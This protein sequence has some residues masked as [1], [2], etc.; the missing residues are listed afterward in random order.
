MQ[1]F[2]STFPDGWPAVGL[3][4]LRVLVGCSAALLGGGSLANGLDLSAVT[5]ALGMAALGSG[6]A[7]LVGLVTPA[8]SLVAGVSAFL[9]ALNSAPQLPLLELDSV[10]AAYVAAVAAA[11]VLLGPGAYSLDA[12]FFG[13]RVILIPN[14]P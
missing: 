9:L 10:M 6:V 2:F 13:R 14:K 3:L 12:R 4:L 11:L 7:V 1:R 5:L 8:A